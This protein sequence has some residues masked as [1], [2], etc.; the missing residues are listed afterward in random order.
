VLE[1]IEKDIGMMSKIIYNA[2]SPYI[3]LSWETRRRKERGG[4]I[5]RDRKAISFYM[6][7]IDV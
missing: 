3:R 4:L 1:M 6:I 2:L 7:Q 5:L